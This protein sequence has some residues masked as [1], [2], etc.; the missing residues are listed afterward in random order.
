MD[1][2]LQDEAQE[3]HRRRWD[4]VLSV[5]SPLLLLALWEVLSRAQLI[6]TRFFSRPSWILT[7]FWDLLVSGELVR[8]VVISLMR[9]LVGFTVAAVPGV[10]LGL[11]MGLFRP[12]RAAVE[13]IIAALYPIPKLALLPLLLLIFGTGETFKIMTIAL[14]CV[15]LITV[16]TLAG[17]VNID[18]VYLDVARNFGAG[19]RDFYLTVALPGALPVIFTGLKLGMGVAL[20]LIVAAEMIGARSGIGYMIWTSYQIFD[21]EQMYV[22]LLL[23]AFF[24]YVS[25]LFINLLERW[26]IPWKRS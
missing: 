4:R 25:T 17:V 12:V 11:T 2:T 20:L 7:T 21:L 18:P 10:I 24:G 19:R 1:S 9:V 15:L 23:M 14:G 13:P 3:L 6:D 22:G 26:I 8:H 5:A 16:N